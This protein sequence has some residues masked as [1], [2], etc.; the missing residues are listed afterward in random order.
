MCIISLAEKVHSVGHRPA[1]FLFGECF[2][3]RI[4]SS[5]GYTF[6]KLALFS[7]HIFNGK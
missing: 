3:F 2:L 1:E 5:L 4:F 7:A 6:D